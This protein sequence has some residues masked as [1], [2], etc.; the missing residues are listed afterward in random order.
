MTRWTNE[1]TEGFD[2]SALDNLNRA[3]TAL[4]GKYF[5]VD[6]GNIADMLNNAWVDGATAND[7]F[8]AVDHRLSA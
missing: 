2:Q 4:E 1:N 6:A 7:L 3:Q 8:V 5:T